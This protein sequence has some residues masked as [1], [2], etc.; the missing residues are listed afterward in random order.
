MAA[1]KLGLMVRGP[2][3]S[4]LGHGA[5]V[6]AGVEEA[7][8]L[9][10]DAAWL[11]TSG[12]GL[13]A[14]TLFGAAAARTERILMG[15]AIVTSFPRHP[16]V[17]VQQVQVLA[18]LAP[19]RF[20]LGIGT[21]HRA[22]ETQTFG[23]NFHK[24]LSHLREYLRLIKALLQGGSVDFQGSFYKSQ[25]T[26]ISPVDVPVMASA[27]QPKSFELCGAEA[28]GAISWV[29]PG[30]YL[31]DVALPAMEMGAEAAGRPVPPLIDGLPVCVHDDMEE[32]RAAIS[33]V[34]NV[35]LTFYQRMFAAAGYPEASNGTWSAAM[36]DA[37]AII[38]N[39]S[40]VREKLEERFSL[41]G[42]EIL[43]TAV[44]AGRDHAA[45]VERTTR[46]LAEYSRA[47]RA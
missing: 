28:D 39:E 46:T 6:L 19:G 2:S 17:M 9:G 22:A 4:S 12:A 30:V 16:V 24:P 43:A 1:K 31:R 33:G 32:A 23:V 34:G 13:D 7:E 35:R 40:R 36:I 29:C 18:H 21:G 27:L 20:R 14:L 45:S 42:T 44:P 47:M 11:T 26:I 10:F 38:G 37:V 3:S 8:D 25:E 41:G 5:D 15:T